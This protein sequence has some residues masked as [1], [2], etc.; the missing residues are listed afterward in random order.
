MLLGW[1][2]LSS[3]VVL[4]L[5]P[6]AVAMG[7]G[8]RPLDG[9][10]PPSLETLPSLSV[11][12]P[13]CN[14]EAT[15]GEALTTL[16]A[17][18][19]P[20]LQIIVVND[21]STDRTGEILDRMAAEDARVLA[22]HVEHLPNGWL[23]KVHALKVGSDQARGDLL[24][25][26]DAD[27]HFNGDALRRAVAIAEGDELDH[28]AVLPKFVAPTFW[29]R[30]LIIAFGAGFM[31]TVRPDRVGKQGTRCYVGVGAFNLVR[32]TAL[33]R[34]EGLEWLR[35]EI[36]DD[37]GLGLLLRRAGARSAFYS[38]GESIS[39]AWYPTV[40][41]LIRGLEK[42][43]YGVACKYRLH[44]L[45]VAAPL[46]LAILIGPFVAV[47][48]LDRPWLVGLGITAMV[49]AHAYHLTIGRIT[50][51]GWLESFVAPY[52]VFVM[53]YIVLRSAFVCVKRGGMSWRG[54]FYPLDA[55][56]RGQ[57]LGL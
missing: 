34:S 24:L 43:M 30:V 57:R 52:G 32:R 44:R 19:Y 46:S 48:Q 21:R 28:L 22:I 56:R 12:I 51:L 10:E 38:A 11:I 3:L 16:L 53:I 54:T 26:T 20:D 13:A 33:E 31:M 36:G 2:T 39:V 42:N 35:M 27:V 23:G 25:L 7:R 47:C 15:I 6:L 8:V 5:G 49:A 14:E 29:L 37:V 41:E 50:R 17:Q 4:A 55:L 45:A 1:A 9:V 40:A 18:D